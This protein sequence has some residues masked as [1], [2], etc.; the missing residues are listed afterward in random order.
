MDANHIRQLVAHY[1]A[2]KKWQVHF[3]LGLVKKGRLRAD[4]VAMTMGGYLVIVEVKSS[5]ADFKT[6]KKWQ[7]YRQF[8]NQLYFAMAPEVY[9]KVKD[10]IPKG[11]GVFIALPNSVK[12]VQKAK[13]QELDIKIQLNIAI[14]MGYRS[15][16]VTKFERKSKTAG[17]KYLALKVVDVISAL[18]KP[19]SR[20]TVLAAA[21]TALKGFV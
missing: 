15:A 10:L 19:R 4:V 6:D 20:K 7:G 11:V 16:D 2:R 5:V 13:R 14:R 1:Y 3:E 17:R 18:P 9:A 8:C 21:E 12:V